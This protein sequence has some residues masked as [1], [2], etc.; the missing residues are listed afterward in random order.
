[1][2]VCVYVGYIHTLPKYNSMCLQH[3]L[4]MYACMRTCVCVCVFMHI[5]VYVYMHIFRC[6]CVCVCVCLCECVCV[7][8]HMCVRVI[9][10]YTLPKQ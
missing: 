3:F 8:M 6:T 4:H 9:Y 7:F 1:M 5:C 2:H 10:S